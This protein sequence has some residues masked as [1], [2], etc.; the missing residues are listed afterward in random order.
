[1]IVSSEMGGVLVTEKLVASVEAKNAVIHRLTDVRKTVPIPN[2]RTETECTASTP[3]A[4]W[5]V[6]RGALP[7][8]SNTVLTRT[9]KPQEY[10]EGDDEPGLPDDIASIDLGAVL[11]GGQQG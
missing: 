4:M 9:Q 11:D 8:S 10:R 3:E 6:R 2:G 1:M 5:A 7:D